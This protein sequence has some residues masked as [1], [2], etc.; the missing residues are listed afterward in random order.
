VGQTVAASLSAPTLFVLAAGLDEM[1]VKAN[2][3][4]SDLGAIKEGQPVTFTVDAYP[5]DT[6]TGS[7][8]QIRL[9]PV[10]EQNVVTYAAMIT[11]PNP[12]LKLKPGLTANVTIE[13]ARRD[14][15]LRVPATA[16]RFKP[17]DAV[18]KALGADGLSPKGTTV[19]QYVDGHLRPLNVTAGASD[20]VVTE[21][22]GEGLTEGTRVATRVTTGQSTTTAA[23]AATSPLM[24]AG[25]GGRR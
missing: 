3:D 21:I 11:A 24:P 18:K 4:E 16:L 10:V 1:Q 2:V 25:V 7:V 6:F 22:S 5:G 17:T 15:V 14:G 20:G 12:E 19:W 23:Q 13:V 8:E 9:N